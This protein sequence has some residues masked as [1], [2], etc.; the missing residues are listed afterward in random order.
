M[1]FV[2][3]YRT[4]A[5]RVQPA[6]GVI[7]G[8]CV[9]D[10]QRAYDLPDEFGG[11][12][13]QLKW[14]MFDSAVVEDRRLREHI[15]P[16]AIDNRVILR[17]NDVLLTASPPPV[18]QVRDFY[19]FEAHVRNARARRGLG[20]I[21][22]W[23]DFPA[24]YFSNAQAVIGAEE[25]VLC[26]RRTQELDYELEIA[27]IIGKAGRNIPA[28]DAETYIAGY[29]IMND[30]SARDIQRREM[31]IGLGPAK[32]KDF[33]TSLGPFLV[34]PDELAD[35]RAGKG[36]DLSMAAR[37]NGVTLSRGN[38]KDIHWSFGELIA[39]AS[40]DCMLLPGDVIGSGTVGTGCI[41]ELG[42]EHVGGWLKPGDVV[43]L[44][45]ER[46]GVLRNTVGALRDQ[47]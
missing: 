42:P 27:T 35:K 1:R 22:E 44:E 15:P 23:Y 47:A 30:W 36:Y 43:E 7:N 13:A 2:F 5:D 20:M 17:L 32:G 8:D 3:F 40:E 45:V 26:P 39:R 46:L 34:T 24:F 19:A 14:I 29:T 37:R 25:T 12:R 16:A 10:V 11:P 4:D 28:H 33:A 6:L 9:I 21:A 18:T 31:A 38:W 41:L